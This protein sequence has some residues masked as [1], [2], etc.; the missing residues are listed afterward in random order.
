MQRG[1]A[2]GAVLTSVALGLREALSGPSEKPPIVREIDGWF[3]G[4]DPI[5]LH[6]EPRPE[7]TWVVL[8][9]WLLRGSRR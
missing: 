4:N 6:L 7:D 2:A 3:S 1:L 5:E 9:P 8:R